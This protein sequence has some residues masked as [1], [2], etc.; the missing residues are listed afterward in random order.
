[1]VRMQ[2]SGLLA[3]ASL[4]PTEAAGGV[5]L[6]AANVKENPWAQQCQEKLQAA[7]KWEGQNWTFAPAMDSGDLPV[8]WLLDDP[9]CSA[10]DSEGI[11]VPVEERDFTFDWLLKNLPAKKSAMQKNGQCTMLSPKSFYVY[12]QDLSCSREQ[13]ANLAAALST[14]GTQSVLAHFGDDSKDALTKDFGYDSWSLILRTHYDAELGSRFGKDKMIP[15]LPGYH[16]GFFAKQSDETEQAWIDEPLV[17]NLLEN[18]LRRVQRSN[19][20]QGIDWDTLLSKWQDVPQIVMDQISGK[21][22]HK[23]QKDLLISWT[24]Y[25][26]QMAKK[27]AK[28][29][30]AKVLDA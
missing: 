13:L 22:V 28:A 18:S 26:E 19:L 1:M 24:R 2:F 10:K 21:D 6:H 17:S 4:A 8:V 3:L 9:R 20:R 25:H 16:S 5:R 14:C 27:I 11:C 30:R 23:E 15:I 7:G 29:V 12:N